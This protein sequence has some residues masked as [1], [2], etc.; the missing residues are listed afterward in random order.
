MLSLMVSLSGGGRLGGLS[1]VSPLLLLFWVETAPFSFSMYKHALADKNVDYVLSAALDS[2]VAVSTVV[3]F[4]CIM[5]P[6]GPLKWWGNEVFMKTADGMGTPWKK[7][8]PQGW[9]GPSS[10]E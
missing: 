2:G 7:L 8:P 6:A 10:W 1:I 9:F 4:F 3:I 5:L